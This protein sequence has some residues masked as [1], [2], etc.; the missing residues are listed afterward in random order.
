[1]TAAYAVAKG[2]IAAELEGEAVLLNLATKAYFRLNPTATVVWQ[3]VERGLDR[4]ALVAELCASFEVERDAASPELDRI[5]GDLEA[6]SLI[7]PGA[8]D[9][10]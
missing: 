1:V 7:Q 9:R 8:P 5:L 2:V 4:A 6:R 3:G 10:A